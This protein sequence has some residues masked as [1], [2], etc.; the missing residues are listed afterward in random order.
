[1]KGRSP[2]NNNEIMLVSACFD[3]NPFE[4]RNRGIFM[5]SVSTGG[6][7]SERLSEKDET[8]APAEIRNISSQEKDDE[9]ATANAG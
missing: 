2:L 9:K 8:Q 7:I 3:A 5:I 4:M 6:R 1:M